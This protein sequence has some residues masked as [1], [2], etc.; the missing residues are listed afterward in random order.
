LGNENANI[1]DV[2]FSADGWS[3][4]VTLAK[5]GVYTVFSLDMPKGEDVYYTY[6]FTSSKGGKTYRYKGTTKLG[7]FG[8]D[9]EGT[10]IDFGAGE[11]VK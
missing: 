6:D 11:E 3:K 1:V 2:I 9:T 4:K 8:V 10:A 5:E 7:S